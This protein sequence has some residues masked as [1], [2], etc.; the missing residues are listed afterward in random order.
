MLAMRVLPKLL[1]IQD[2]PSTVT[3]TWTPEAAVSAMAHGLT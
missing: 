3:P 2:L 1:Q